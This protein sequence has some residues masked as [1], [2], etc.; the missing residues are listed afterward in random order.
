MILPLWPLLQKV[1]PSLVARRISI[2][3]PVDPRKSACYLFVNP[4]VMDNATNM[5]KSQL[6]LYLDK[7]S[8]TPNKN[9][10]I[11]DHSWNR[12]MLLEMDSINF[13]VTIS[14]LQ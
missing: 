14:Q 11:L 8:Q 3:T 6:D 2:E 10:Q 9:E 12:R 1:E 7:S 13:K 4:I 5:P